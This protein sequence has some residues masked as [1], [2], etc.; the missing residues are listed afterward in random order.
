M[1][2]VEEPAML[3]GRTQSIGHCRKCVDRTAS[4]LANYHSIK[5]D[6]ESVLALT[7]SHSITHL[8][9]RIALIAAHGRCMFSFGRCLSSSVVFVS[10]MKFKQRAKVESRTQ[11]KGGQVREIRTTDRSDKT[12]PRRDA[13]SVAVKSTSQ[14]PPPGKLHM[15]VP[16]LVDLPATPPPPILFYIV[17]RTTTE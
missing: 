4:A 11:G 1:I 9:V 14:T 8:L 16:V 10:L 12:G 6:S 7:K 5:T 17:L 2:L 15:L 3:V 13:T